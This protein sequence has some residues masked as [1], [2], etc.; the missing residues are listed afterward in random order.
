GSERNGVPRTQPSGR[1][2]TTSSESRVAPVFVAQRASVDLPAPLTPVTS[3][4]LPFQ[5]TQEACTRT[6]P[7]RSIAKEKRPLNAKASPSGLASPLT[8]IPVGSD[9]YLPTAP[10]EDSN[11]DQSGPSSRGPP[12]S[13]STWSP[14]R[15]SSRVHRK[16]STFSR[17]AIGPKADAATR[18]S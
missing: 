12:I 1:T 9:R 10:L 6:P 7:R 11:E 16:A 3:A 15:E 2:P 5:D 8:S 4:A 14:D 18:T 13:N 17:C